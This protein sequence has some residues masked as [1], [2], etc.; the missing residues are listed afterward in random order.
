MIAIF[1]PS[2]RGNFTILRHYDF[3]HLE[4]AF[5]EDIL[6]LIDSGIGEKLA[7]CLTASLPLVIFSIDLDRVF[8]RL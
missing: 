3:S 4:N 5:I 1:E 2:F 8:T 7:S 6:P